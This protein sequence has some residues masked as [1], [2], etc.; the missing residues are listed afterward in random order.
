MVM[1]SEKFNNLSPDDAGIILELS[2]KID[3]VTAER[4]VKAV[5]DRKF[6]IETSQ[7]EKQLLV[8]NTTEHYD[9]LVSD[10]RTCEYVAAYGINIMRPVSMGTFR[11]GTLAYQLYTWYDGDDL[12]EALTHMSHAEQFSAGK[13]AGEL[14]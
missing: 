14:L 11:E 4:L 5:T 6:C 9:W 1:K 8:I 2:Q 13:K 7:G 10:F 3:I 12:E